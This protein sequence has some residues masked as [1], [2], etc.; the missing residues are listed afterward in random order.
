MRVGE[1]KDRAAKIDGVDV[2]VFASREQRHKGWNRTEAVTYYTIV[3]KGEGRAFV[4]GMSYKSA[5]TRFRLR[6]A[7]IATGRV[8]DDPSY[9]YGI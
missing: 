6:M 1:S 3:I 8:V 5:V 2:I 4:K 9:R 7:D